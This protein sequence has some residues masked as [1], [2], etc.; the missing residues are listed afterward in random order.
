M[1]H[2]G[3]FSRSAVN[4]ES[5]AKTGLSGIV[6]GIIM[7]C[8]LL[9]LTPLFEYIPQ[10]CCPF[11]VLDLFYESDLSLSV[12]I[13]LTTVEDFPFQSKPFSGHNASEAPLT[14]SSYLK[15]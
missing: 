8:A 13:C 12:V 2:V 15:D 4:N 10:V 1:C 9:F 11:F 7:C 3:S 6:M 5:G 14:M